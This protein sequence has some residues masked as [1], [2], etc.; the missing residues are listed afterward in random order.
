LISTFWLGT[1]YHSTRQFNG[2]ALLLPQ[3]FGLERRQLLRHAEEAFFMEVQT[4]DPQTSPHEGACDLKD[5]VRASTRSLS[6]VR[7]N[8]SK[9][10]SFRA[11]VEFCH[12]LSG[13]EIKCSVPEATKPVSVAKRKH[14][15]LDLPRPLSGQRRAYSCLNVPR[16]MVQGKSANQRTWKWR[17]F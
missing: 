11:L 10:C 7:P 12:S 13:Q 6:V 2:L 16:E 1:S 3:K 5:L 14:G 8:A 4:Q 15:L 17:P 9:T